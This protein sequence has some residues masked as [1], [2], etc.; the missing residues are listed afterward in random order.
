MVAALPA[1]VALACT[2]LPTGP[3][4]GFLPPVRGIT[5]VNWTRDGYG[6]AEAQASLDALAATGAGTVVIVVTGYQADAGASSVR[7]D[8]PRTPS[9]T[10]VTQLVSR[11][12]TLGLRVALKPHVDLDDGSWRGWIA[13]RDPAAWFDSYRAFLLPWAQLARTLAVEQFAIGTELAGTLAHEDQWRAT[14]AAVRAACPSELIYAASWDEAAR[15]PFWDALDLI[16]V[17][18]YFPVA[19]RR[20][21]GR[22]EM[23][24]GWQPWLDRLSALHRRAGRDILFSE[25]GYR[26]LDGAGMA[27]Y[28][29]A[30]G[31]TLDLGEQADLYWAALQA[32]GDRTWIRGFWWWDWPADGSGGPADGGYTARG[33]PA[34]AELAATW[35][36]T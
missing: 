3:V 20:D 26:S 19:R 9:Q 13:P 23:L 4:R 29:F 25:V 11:A 1:L 16:G 31:A 7:G 36:G 17:D 30:S 22:L 35:G 2:T 12:R 15:V 6:T 10:A 5:I 28:A 34:A 18:A 24:A 33:K 14:I 32:T 21:A 27:P 8:D